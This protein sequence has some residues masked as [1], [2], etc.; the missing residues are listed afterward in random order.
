MKKV[1]ILFLSHNFN[2]F[3]GGIEVISEILATSFSEE[4]YEV[5]LLTWT[6]MLGN[7]SFPFKIVRNPN[8]IKIIR[9]FLWA[10]IVFENNPC[11]RLAWPALLIFKPLIT[12]L[13]TWIN[14]PDNSIELRDKLKKYIWLKRSTKV[15]AVSDAIRKEVFNNATIINNPYRS[16]QFV[17]KNTIIKCAD[18]IFLGRLVSDKGVHLAIEALYKLN[19]LTTGIKFI[20]EK[21]LLTIVGTGPEYSDLLRIVNELNLQDQVSFTGALQG[22]EVV[23]YL[24]KHRFL[25]VPSIWDEPFGVVALEAIACGCIPIVS[26]TGGLPEA[27]VNAGLT[28]ERGSVQALVSCIENVLHNPVLEQQLLDAGPTH[29]VNFRAETVAR[30]YL[31]IIES[32]VS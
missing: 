1:K 15:I 13:H 17:V 23:E 8:K 24:N 18:F 14:R 21:P 10:D 3:I 30:H 26:D 31:N 28:F 22:E 25:L 32:V 12:V 6:R 5:H 2:P 7:K 19:D 27:V 9:E 16:E 11:L 20:T 29:L 4:G